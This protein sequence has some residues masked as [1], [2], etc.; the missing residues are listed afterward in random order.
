[1]VRKNKIVLPIKG[2]CQCGNI[3]YRIKAL[4]LTLYA[5]HCKECQLQS[6]SAFG[7]SLR[8]LRDDIDVEG[9]L[10]A[11][12]KNKNSEKEQTVEFCPKCGVRLFHKR[13]SSPMTLN[14]KAGTI[15]DSRNFHPVG[16]IWVV[17]KAPWF[18]IPDGSIVYDKQPE[19]Y[20]TLI[21][22]WQRLNI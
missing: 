12:V 10:S 8:V 17:R 11:W 16:H 21:E 18:K 20:D 7:M 13:T 4:P 6:A 14:V 2:G 22:E 1:M 3:R 15:D 5:C 9:D 19:N